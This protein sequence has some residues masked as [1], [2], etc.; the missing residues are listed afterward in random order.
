MEDVEFKRLIVKARSL[1]RKHAKAIEDAEEE[2]VRR[3]GINP[4]DI[5]DDGWI[6]TVHYG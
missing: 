1:A 3:Y 5:D 4:S 2:Y 6:D